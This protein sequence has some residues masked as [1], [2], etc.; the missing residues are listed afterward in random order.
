MA[1]LS[2]A[3]RVITMM[4]AFLMVSNVPTIARASV[5]SAA[6]LGMAVAPP[7]PGAPRAE[8]ASDELAS[9]ELAS[10]PRAPAEESGGIGLIRTATPTQGPIIHVIDARP[11]PER[12]VIKLA[13]YINSASAQSGSVV[14]V[15][16]NYQ[17]VCTL[18]CGVP[19]DNSERP[20]FFF[21]REW[22]AN[23]PHFVSLLQ[24]TDGNSGRGG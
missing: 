11:D 14:H 1:P 18:P 9:D 12:G 22:K 3:A 16:V 5:T 17:D 21:I 7:Q 15:T 24:T 23:F 13:R 19:V 20:L 8:N 6:P 10:D 2:T 4:V